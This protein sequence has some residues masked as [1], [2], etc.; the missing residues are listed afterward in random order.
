[1]MTDPTPPVPPTIGVV[2]LAELKRLSG[3][4]LLTGMMAGRYPGPPIALTLDFR[5]TEV[6][7][8]RAVFQG[9]PTFAVY[10]PIGSVH[11]GYMATL[12]DS[13][14]GCAVHSLLEPGQGYTSLEIKI[15]FTRALTDKTGLVTATGRVLTSGRRAATAEGHLT[16][17]QGRILA[18]GT[19]TC[20]VFDL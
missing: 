15:N 18:H 16:D 12:L 11:G 6:E 3:V 19:T 7:R 14:M 8:G 2:P 9:T 17:A 5:L 10:N 20:L 1:M 13:C 4:E